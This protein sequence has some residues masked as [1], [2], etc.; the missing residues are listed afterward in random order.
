[1][2]PR[3]LIAE[4][5]YGCPGRQPVFGRWN[6]RQMWLNRGKRVEMRERVAT[7]L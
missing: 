5:D 1:M 2:G 7:E 6:T 3:L 4:A